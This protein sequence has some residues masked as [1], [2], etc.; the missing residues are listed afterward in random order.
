MGMSD[1]LFDALSGVIKMNATVTELAEDIKMLAK[2]VRE[3]DKRLIRIE[4][5][6]EIVER[7][8]HLPKD[9]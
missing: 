4:T 9:L 8:R 1:K 2:E 3:I 5:F 6:F 7:Q